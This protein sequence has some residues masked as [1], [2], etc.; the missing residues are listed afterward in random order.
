MPRSS[1]SIRRHR[2]FVGVN[3]DGATVRVNDQ[4]LLK[5]WRSVLRLREGDDVVLVGQSGVEAIARI[6]ELGKFAADLDIIERQAN[7]REPQ[8]DVT[9]YCALLKR[10]NFEWVAQKAT[11]VGVSRIV[12]VLT[13]RTVKLHVKA[14][15]LQAIIREAAEQS[16]RGKIPQLGEIITL[17]AALSES[18][19]VAQRY[20]F[21]LGGEMV[22]GMAAMTAAK[23]AVL[24]IGPEGGWTDAERA[25]AREAKC[26]MASLGP[27]TLRAETAAVV[28]SYLLAHQQEIS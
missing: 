23:S 9:L 7:R 21:D 6:K 22:P 4:D 18:N 1:Q 10:E 5:Q 28:A 17:A 24:F 20:F 26:T 2:F 15:R 12:P 13:E 25:A 8:V 3:V 16:G 19:G 11:E 14:E 27:L